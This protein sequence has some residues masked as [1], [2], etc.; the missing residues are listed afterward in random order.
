MR[1]SNLWG[2]FICNLPVSCSGSCLGGR[3][4]VSLCCQRLG[5]MLAHGYFFSDRLVCISPPCQ[6]LAIKARME[7]ARHATHLT[8][9]RTGAGNLPEATPAHQCDR[10]TGT[11]FSTSGSLNSGSSSS[12]LDPTLGKFELPVCELAW[13]PVSVPD[14]CIAAITDLAF[15]NLFITSSTL[16]F[17]LIRDAFRVAT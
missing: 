15:K 10:L 3:V 4:R 9:S 8:D 1:S 7:E 14:T 12:A 17:I 6:R 13:Q 11:R 5:L 16:R 2:W